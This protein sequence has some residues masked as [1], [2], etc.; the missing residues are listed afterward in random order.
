MDRESFT[1]KPGIAIKHEEQ[2][3]AAV[4]PLIVPF[5]VSRLTFHHSPN[6]CDYEKNRHSLRAG[7]IVPAGLC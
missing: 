4:T 2:Q 5:A 3:S 1:L 6:N 7:K